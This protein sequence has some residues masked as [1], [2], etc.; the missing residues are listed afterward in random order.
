MLTEQQV[1]TL[2]K[3]AQ[4]AAREQDW[5]LAIGF[6][7][8]AEQLAPHEFRLAN[9][10]ANTHW[11]ADQTQEAFHAYRQAV[12]VEPSDPRPWRGLGNVL[13]DLNRFEEASRAYQQSRLL[14]DSPETSWNHSQVLIGLEMYQEAW[15]LSEERLKLSTART[16]RTDAGWPGLHSGP[17]SDL[18]VWSEQGFG[19]TFQFLRW[20][21]PLSEQIGGQPVRLEVERPLVPLMSEGL[22]WMPAPPIVVAKQSVPEP[23]RSHISLMSLP[24]RLGGSTLTEKAFAEGPYLR[25]TSSKN[26]HQTRR[27]GVAWAAGRKLDEPF[28][29]RE[30]RKRTLP[31]EALDQLLR[32]LRRLHIAPVNLQVGPDRDELEPALDDLFEDALPP[33]ADFLAAGRLIQQMDAVVSVDTAMAHQCGAQGVVCH[34]LLPWSSDPRWLRNRCDTPWYPSL[35]LWRQGKERRW[36]PAINQLLSH[37]RT[38]S[39]SDRGT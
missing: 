35:R 39:P 8:Q 16:Y 19:D 11:L 32:G 12:L 30:Y 36:E 20:M 9:N 5:E 2:F 26:L 33:S 38:I 25:I 14:L 3:R 21:I 27:I 28:P 31:P 15:C 23:V 13:R 29:A 4:E 1:A 17:I 34:V 6:Y 18:S 24:S 10:R 7:Q 37:L 22:A